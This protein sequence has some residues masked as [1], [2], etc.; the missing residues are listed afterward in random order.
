MADKSRQAVRFHDLIWVQFLADLTLSD[1]KWKKGL[2]TLTVKV[3]TLMGPLLD[4]WLQY[5]KNGKRS[6]LSFLCDVLTERCSDEEATEF[7]QI[8]VAC[9]PEV[10][11]AYNTVLNYGAFLI[12]RHFLAKSM[13][14]AALIAAEDSDLATCF[15]AAGRMPELVNSLALSSRN[16][17]QGE[18]TGSKASKSKK[19]LDGETLDLWNVKPLSKAA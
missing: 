15:M 3:E 7:E 5:P 13:D 12:S 4:G 8:R 16:M 9:L 19:K 6:V 14:L 18:E 11:L 10:I 17:I 1:T 2:Q